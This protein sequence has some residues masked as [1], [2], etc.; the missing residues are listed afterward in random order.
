VAD[1][2]DLVVDVLRCVVDDA[3]LVGDTLRSSADV[4]ESMA[5]ARRLLA[6][7]PRALADDGTA[8]AC[9]TVADDD[10]LLAD[11]KRRG[12]GACRVVIGDVGLVADTFD[13]M[14]GALGMVVSALRRPADLATVTSPPSDDADLVADTMRRGIGACRAVVDD[15]DLVADTMPP[16]SDV[17]DTSDSA[18]SSGFCG[19]WSALRRAAMR[20]LRRTAVGSFVRSDPLACNSTADVQSSG[21]RNSPVVSIGNVRFANRTSSSSGSRK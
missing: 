14:V 3:G 19:F 2:D 1:D 17:A 6:D 21:K 4:S 7:A 9:R 15:A 11:P 10:D 18:S 8:A 20:S 12:T 13:S 5:D 16:L